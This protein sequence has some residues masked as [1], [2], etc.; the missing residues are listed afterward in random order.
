MLNQFEIAG[1][2]VIGRRHRQ[3]GKNNQDAMYWQADERALIGIVCDGCG[4]H[5]HSEVGAKIGARIVAAEIARMLAVATHP[6]TDN[7]WASPVV[8]ENI[9]LNTLSQINLSVQ[10]LG[11]DRQ[12]IIC[13]YFLFTVVG[14]LI[15]PMQTI[16]FSIG[17]GLIIIN[18]EE[19]PLGPFSDNAPPYFTYGLSDAAVGGIPQKDMAFKISGC[20]PT[21]DLDRILIGT[22]GV[23]DL[24]NAEHKNLPGKETPVGPLRQFFDEDRFF[25]NPDLL[26]RRLT[27]INRDT[28]NYVRNGHCHIIE[29]KKSYGL[30][31]DDT[32]I[33]AVRRKP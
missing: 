19:I 12:Q 8:W 26:R 2:Q 25:Q 17:D 6:D 1:G 20:I 28:V 29:I 14:F 9:R 24:K 16:L 31:P 7:E 10:S 32:T 33:I 27:L 3:T 23:I 21:A 15:T 5:P 4:S 11:N 13:D 22:D 30:L 18:D